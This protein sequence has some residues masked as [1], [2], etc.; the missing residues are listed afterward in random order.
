MKNCLICGTDK[1]IE[2]RAKC[3]TVLCVECY[4][5]TPQKVSKK[6]F[7]KA[8]FKDEKNILKNIVNEF[9]NDYICSIYTLKEYIKQT[10]KQG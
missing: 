10:T 5:M 9:Y 8:Y 7:T 4:I 6:D 3:K 1:Y 2:Y